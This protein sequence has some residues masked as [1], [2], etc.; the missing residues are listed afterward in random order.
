VGVTRSS[1][2]RAMVFQSTTKFLPGSRSFLGSL[3]FITDKFGYLSLQ[4][5]ESREVI[6]SGIDRLPLAPV[7]VGLINE[8][9]LGHRL[10]E[11]GK[12]DPD[13]AGDKANHTLAVLAATTDPI[14]QSLPESNSKGGGEVYMVGNREELPEKIVEE[15]Q[16]EPDEEIARVAHFVRETERGKRNNDLQNDSGASDDEPRDGAPTRRHHP[17]LNS[18]RPID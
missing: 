16:R 15:I 17:K 9:Q 13:P 5:P 12:T 8:A 7:R 14:Y 1:F 3:L 10:S 6:E 2:V 11:L 4:E 18:R